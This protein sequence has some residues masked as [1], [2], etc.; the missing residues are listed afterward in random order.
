MLGGLREKA[1]PSHRATPNLDSGTKFS[2]DPQNLDPQDWIDAEGEEEDHLP[3]QAS[4]SSSLDG[5]VSG[6]RVTSPR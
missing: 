5:V 6:E 1:F 2:T 4:S 3:V